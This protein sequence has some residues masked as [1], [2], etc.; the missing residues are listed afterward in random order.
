MGVP[1]LDIVHSRSL[2][3]INLKTFPFE[4]SFNFCCKSNNDCSIRVFQVSKCVLCTDFTMSRSMGGALVLPLVENKL[5]C[6][7]V[8][9]ING[10]IEDNSYYKCTLQL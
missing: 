4:H 7:E 5:Y 2:Y 6:I 8:Q 10:Q 9:E 1:K 3:K